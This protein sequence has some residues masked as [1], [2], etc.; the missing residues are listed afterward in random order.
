MWL[1]GLQ[2]ICKWLQVE[3]VIAISLLG[4]RTAFI[5]QSTRLILLGN[6]EDLAGHTRLPYLT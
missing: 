3:V 6:G 1:A 2:K 5:K 4:L